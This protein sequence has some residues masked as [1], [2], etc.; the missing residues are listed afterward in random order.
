M[1]HNS[2]TTRIIEVLD[3]LNNEQRPSTINSYII[4]I[5][6]SLKTAS[7]TEIIEFTQIEFELGLE[8][9]EVGEAA[10]F[11]VKEGQLMLIGEKYSL[12]ELA[13]TSMSARIHASNEQEEKLKA[14]FYKNIERLSDT[15]LNQDE[16][17]ELF[18]EFKGYIH[19]NFFYYGKAAISMLG[20]R[21]ETNGLTTQQ[22]FKLY[23]DRLSVKLRKS[24]FA[25]ID[26]LASNSSILELEYYES[27]ADRAEQ[28]FALGLSKELAQELAS[29]QKI[30]WTV[31]VDTNFLLSV[32][33]VRANTM[34]PAVDSLLRIIDESKEYFTIKLSYLKPT[35][36]ELRAC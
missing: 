26:N 9:T 6:S 30:D 4:Y 35:Y 33:Q 19:E 20:S 2:N 12:T 23:S 25:Y 10:N 7:L 36:K 8:R 34:N 11:L 18:K 14:N 22:V 28:F 16:L 27:L 17:D 5:I 1:K 29:S 32:L 24:F 15:E 13:K 31:F 21:G 3:L